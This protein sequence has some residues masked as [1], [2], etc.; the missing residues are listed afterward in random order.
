MSISFRLIRILISFCNIIFTEGDGGEREREIER[1]TERDRERQR[2][3]ERQRDTER[4]L[5]V[6][7][8]SH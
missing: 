1:E 3:S 5:L 4:E 6:F 7:S 8:K 2:E